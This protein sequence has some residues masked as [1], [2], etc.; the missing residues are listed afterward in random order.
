MTSKHVIRLDNE[1]IIFIILISQRWITVSLAMF[2][3]LKQTTPLALLYARRR[4]GNS[5]EKASG[6]RLHAQASRPSGP[7]CGDEL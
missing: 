1:Y 4:S 3:S 5:A 2:T 7:R 6:R